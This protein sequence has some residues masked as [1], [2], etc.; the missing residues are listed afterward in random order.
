MSF[1]V[2]IFSTTEVVLEVKIILLQQLKSKNCTTRNISMETLDKKTEMA[3]ND[4]PC[5]Y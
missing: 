3:C 4:F 5:L 2:L 1:L